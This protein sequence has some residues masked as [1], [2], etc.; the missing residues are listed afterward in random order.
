MFSFLV[1]NLVMRFV[2]YSDNYWVIISPECLLVVGGP[3]LSF[4]LSGLLVSNTVLPEEQC[5]A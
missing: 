1:G 2:N 3:D 5:V 4:V